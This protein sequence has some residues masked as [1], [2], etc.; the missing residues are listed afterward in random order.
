MTDD[1]K[2]EAIIYSLETHALGDIQRASAGASKMGAFILCSCL[3]DAISGF[4]KGSDTTRTDYTKFV[5]KR[6]GAYNAT[7]L[8]TDL[9]CKLVHSYSEGGSYSFIDGQSQLHGASHGSKT[10]INLENFIADITAALAAFAADIR[11][12]DTALRI[13]ALNRLNSNGVIGVGVAQVLQPAPN[14]S[15]ANATLSGAN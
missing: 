2:I 11:G 3:I 5:G 6:L 9:R 13:K 12:A 15:A 1:E 4:E 8:Y 7:N 10:V 14:L